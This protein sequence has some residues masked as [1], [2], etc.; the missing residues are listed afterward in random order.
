VVL[1]EPALDR[2]AA[3][4]LVERGVARAAA[5]GVAARR[6]AAFWCAF[7]AAGSTGRAPASVATV[8][9]LASVTKPF[10]ALT[11]ARLVGRGA[12]GY[13]TAL[14]D[15]V[16]EARST[17]SAGL[18]LELFLSH[19]AGLEA[20]LPLYAA[21]TAGRP[22]E[23]S[24]ALGRAARARRADA[25]GSAPPGGFD[26]V[27]SDLGYLLAGVA[28][29]RASGDALDATVFR[30]VAAPLGL[31]ARSARQWLASGEDF[32]A[33]V[34]PTEHATFRG[35]ELRGVVHDENAW[36]LAGHG[37]AGHAGLFATVR[38]VVLLGCALLDGLSGRKPSWLGADELAFL[39]S[40]RPRGSLRCGF[41]AKSGATPAAGP[42]ASACSFG[43]L[44]FT[45]TSL[46]CDPEA[47]VVTVVLTNRVCPTRE[48][49]AIRAAR[50]RVHEALF[51]IGRG[52]PGQGLVRDDPA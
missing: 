38:D 14:A 29:S 9:D 42:S 11:A 35:A 41:D 2:L 10:I 3:S 18:P 4:E 19:R 33:R 43:H 6:G 12:L 34:A 31:R 32:L 50:P 7:G 48:N 28:L 46:W 30:E 47:E 22:V 36:A 45:G 16:A 40:E 5:I 51:A 26:P 21:L 20:H 49:T 25:P 17:D 8:F 52:G 27:Y 23:V 1:T 15:L 44:G 37:L 39:V 13:D 24:R